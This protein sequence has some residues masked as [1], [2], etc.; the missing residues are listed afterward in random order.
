MIQE[1]EISSLDLRY[2]SHRMKNAAAEKKLL[3]SIQEN[4]IRE[5]LQGVDIATPPS[6]QSPGLTQSRILLNGF[7]R[8]RCAKKLSIDIIPYSSLGSDEAFGLITLLK[9]ATLEC[10]NPHHFGAGQVGRP[11]AQ[12][13]QVECI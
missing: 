12:S 5:P 4:G 1:V 10:Q 3:T 11:T 7:K 2:Q 8:Y 9:I 6:T 13:S